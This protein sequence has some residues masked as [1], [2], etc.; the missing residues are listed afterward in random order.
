[1]YFFIIKNHYTN[2]EIPNI[3]ILLLLSKRT[4][5]LYLYNNIYFLIIYILY[6]IVTN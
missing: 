1:M 3:I 4:Q 6:C 2:T 5:L